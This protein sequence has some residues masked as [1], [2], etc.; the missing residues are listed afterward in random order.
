MAAQTVDTTWMWHPSFTEERSGTAGLFVHFRR[1]LIIKDPVPASLRVYITADTKYKLY[2]NHQLVRFGPVKGDRS[3]WFNNKVD[4]APYLVI[5]V[6]HICIHVLRF[7][8]ATAYASSFSRLPSGGVRI[9]PV[10]PDDLWGKQVQSS[11]LWETT[12]D[13][14]TVLRIDESED[15]FLNIYEKSVPVLSDEWIWLRA[16]LLEFQSSTGLSPPRRLSD[17]MIPDMQTN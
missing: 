16:K 11:Q 3:F 15:D 13:P 6:N 17:R 12:I 14:T 5:G 7:F 1:T 10:D 8:Y 2:V 4:L 9:G